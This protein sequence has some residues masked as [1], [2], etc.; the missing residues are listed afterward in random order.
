MCNHHDGHALA[1]SQAIHA[2]K[3]TLLGLVIDLSGGLIEKD[4][5]AFSLQQGVG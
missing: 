2:L 4:H 3:H 1:V 5:L